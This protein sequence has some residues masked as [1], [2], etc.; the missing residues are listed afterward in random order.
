MPSKTRCFVSF[1]ETKNFDEALVESI[2]PVAASLLATPECNEGGCEAF[3]VAHAASLHLYRAAHKG[4][5]AQRKSPR[6]IRRTADA[7][8]FVGG[9]IE[10]RA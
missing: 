8:A 5:I 9:N 7:D 10:N 3:D 2:S 6:Q 4:T 1:I